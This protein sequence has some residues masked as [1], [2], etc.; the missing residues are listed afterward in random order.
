M[1]FLSNI[2]LTSLA[3]VLGDLFSLILSVFVGLGL[4]GTTTP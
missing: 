4:P 3:Q 1:N 2:F